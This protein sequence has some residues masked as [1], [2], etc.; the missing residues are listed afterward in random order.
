MTEWGLWGA[1]E[2]A[3]A[4]IVLFAI[5]LAALLWS[6]GRAPWSLGWRAACA[7]LK[8]T[9]LAALALCLV[10]PLAGGVR[11]R[12]GAN[13]FAVA[14]DNSQSMRVRDPGGG[15]TRGEELQQMLL[16]ESRWQTRLGRQFDV[17]RFAIDH[18]L[19]DAKDFTGL[20]FAGEATGLV[21][22]LGELERRFRGL[23]VGGVLLFTDGNSTDAFSESLDWSGVP[24]VY[25]VAVG[26]HDVL[27][28]VCVESIS[29]RQTNF[30]TAPVTVHADIRSTGAGERDVQVRL[31]DEQSSTIDTKTVHVRAGSEVATARFQVRPEHAGVNVFYVTAAGGADEAVEA[32]NTRGVVVDNGKGPFRVLYVSGRPNWDFKFLR[33]ALADD[34]QLELVGL[35]RIANR[36]PK[37]TFRRRGE[38]SGNQ[39]FD[40]FNR[41]DEDTA[42]RYDEPVLTRIGTR[43]EQELRDGFPKSADELYAYDAIVLDDVEAEF[44][45]PDQLAMIEGFV[46]RRGGGLLMAGGG[47][48][49]AEGG[50]RL[51]PV[52]GLLP[53]YLERDAADRRAAGGSGFRL[54]LTREGWL[55]DWVRLRKTQD[56]EQARLGGMPAFQTSNAVGNLKP[57]A[58]ELARVADAS[59]A[60]HPALVAQR[61]GRGRSAALL[62]A[63]VWRW[64]LRR[65]EVDNDDL[66]KS[67]RQTIRWLVADVPRPVEVEVDAAPDGQTSAHAQLIKVRVH[68]AEY[69]PLENATLQVTVRTPDG[70]QVKLSAEADDEEAG[71]YVAQHHSRTPGPH[72]VSVEA[73]GPDGS[74]LGGCEGGW[75]AEPLADE[76]RRLRVNR[77]LLED[78]A[79]RTG[80][81][82]VELDELDG[83]VAGLEQRK[84]PVT[85]TW[86]NPLWHHPA[87]FTFAIACLIGEWGLR[88]WKGLA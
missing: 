55:Q 10:E 50:Y 59:G 82:V 78:I 13:L 18:R 57:G 73:A 64:G 23:P 7:A 70:R 79:A 15:K 34:D 4:A 83:F 41:D 3:G 42:E 36:E 86:I 87:F 16:A 49:F 44:F 65:A 29:V 14:V 26:A 62:V 85:E 54:V 45:S 35:I 12:P 77:P 66:E 80:G 75:V 19:H 48:S 25:P 56:E 39:L 47:G 30:E 68:D 88:R 61:F 69:L 11:P 28:D 81:Q 1:P 5:G 21:S 63:D 32:N 24:P 2:W 71:L 6:Y 22:G 33:R 74:P 76:F 8:A 17:R 43:D 67:W 31:L 60:A 9:G 53:V 52:G 27:P 38:G 40:G 20:D 46:S 37:F 72:R 51:T 58:V 84:M